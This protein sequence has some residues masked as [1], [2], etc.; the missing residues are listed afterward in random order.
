M[1]EIKAYQCEYCKKI[2]RTKTGIK[3]H[4]KKCSANPEANNCKNCVNACLRE[5]DLYKEP[6]C[7][8]YEMFIFQND[9]EQNAYFEE[10]EIGY[11]YSGQ[12][13]NIPYTCYNF[14]SKGT[15]GF[16]KE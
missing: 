13:F 16:E 11:H 5:T 6:Y 15:S 7:R 4:E 9:K 14:E 3:L 2:S 10:C 1:K 8:A 12:E